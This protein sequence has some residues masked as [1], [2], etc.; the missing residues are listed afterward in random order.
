MGCS[1]SKDNSNSNI[2][3]VK[4]ASSKVKSKFDI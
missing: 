3:N 1:G 2:K 4:G